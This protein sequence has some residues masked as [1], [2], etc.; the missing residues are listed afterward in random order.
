MRI[1]VAMDSFKG[2]LSS[3]EAAKAV[4]EALESLEAGFDVKV[5]PFADGG[6]GSLDAVRESGAS[7]TVSLTVKDPLLRDIESC[8]LIVGGD[9]AVIEMARAS[10]LGLLLEK[11]RNPMI[12]STYGLGEM[13]KDALERGIRKF[14]VFIGGSSTN[15]GGSGMLE[16]LGFAFKDRNGKRIKPG[17]EGLES[18]CSI[19]DTPLKSLIEASS[20]TVACDVDNPLLGEN[21]ATH[22]FSPQKGADEKMVIRMEKA[23]ARYAEVCTDFLGRDM[24]KSRGAGAAGG[25]GFA[26]GAFLGAVP[27]SGTNI[28]IRMLSLEE[29]MSDCDL[30][31]TGE[32]RFD[33]QSYMG[34]CCMILV[35][36]AKNKGKKTCLICGSIE[37]GAL[38]DDGIVDM[39]YA[40]LPEGAFVSEDK[41]RENAYSTLYDKALEMGRSIM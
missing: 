35:R 38:Q 33:R 17:A 7:E 5:C 41:L 19:E 18:V 13:I 36:L 11:E 20:I 24:S 29:R 26:L 34:K 21:G 4:K 3:L 16:A 12:T 9:T 6:E 37:E 15:D 14:Y 23:M 40:C 30:F 10:G 1:L 8:Y 32:G 22:L 28:M 25:V 2:T 39:S 27:E 31:I